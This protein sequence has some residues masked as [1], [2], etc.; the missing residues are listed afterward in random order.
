MGALQVAK[1]SSAANEAIGL[2]VARGPGTTRKPILVHGY[3]VSPRGADFAA[4]VQIYF[5]NN[6]GGL[7][8]EQLQSGD[9]TPDINATAKYTSDFTSTDDGWDDNSGTAPT[10]ANNQTVDSVIDCLKIT[11]TG[12]ADNLSIK[13]DGAVDNTTQYQLSFDYFAETGALLVALGLG[14]DG[15][16]WYLAFDHDSG[17]HPA[18]VFNAWQTGVLIYG[19]S[20]AVNLELTA[21]TAINNQAEDLF[22]AGKYIAF[23][24][25]VLSSITNDGDWTRSADTEFAWD[26]YQGKI[27]ADAG[28][29]G[30]VTYAGTNPL[31]QIDGIYQ[32]SCAVSSWVAGDLWLTLGGITGID[33]DAN[34]TY[35]VNWI[36]TA[37]T[38]LVL[39]AD[40]DGD[41]DLDSVSLKRV[42]K[43]NSSPLT[44]SDSIYDTS[45]RSG[46]AVPVITTFPKP[47]ICPEGWYMH[48]TDAGAS[49]IMDINVFY[50]YM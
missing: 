19:L 41:G 21:Y 22:G 17:K 43:V 48:F 5:M 29:G 26:F 33:M 9:F 35:V 8:A 12:G 30:T 1:I 27:S 32:T 2:G 11:D 10:F 36:P 3:S 39:N 45:I 47:I 20:D 15:D 25:M 37:T 4:D 23:K 46:V 18:T 42:N 6:Y 28:A 24:N 38:T 44:L 13:N 16:A 14:A 40:G 31:V 49:C 50:E 34:G 7:G